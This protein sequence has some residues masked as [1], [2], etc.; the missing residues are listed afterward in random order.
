MENNTRRNFLQKTMMASASIPILNLAFMESLKAGIAEHKDKSA[1]EIAADETFWYQIQKAYTVSPHFTNL[2]NGYFSLA[3][4]EVLEAQ[5]KNIRMINEQPSWYMRKRQWE[6]RAAIKERLAN[7]AGVSPEEIALLR[8][9]TEALNIVIQGID[10]QAGDEAIVSDQDYGSMLEAFDMR[11]KRFGIVVKKVNIPLHPKSD[12]EIV[13]LF[14]SAITPKTKVIHVTHLINL[15]GQILPVKKIADMAHSKGIEVISDSA[16]A[17]GQLNFKIPELDCDYMGTSLHK[18]LGCPLG[19][20]MLYVKKE[21]IKGL[22][23]LMGDVNM[24]DDDIRKLEHIGTHPCSADL[25]IANA[26]KFHEMIGADRKAAR[27]FYLKNYWTEKAADIPNVIINTPKEKSRSCAIA[28]VGIEGISPA[29][30]AEILYKRY[31]IFTV[32]IDHTAIKGVRVTP[33][34]YTTTSELDN[35]VKALEEISES[36]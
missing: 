21:K 32:A 31:K 17:F 28:N 14:E 36:M 30:L 35:F 20:G 22:W 24:P 8:N 16:H 3:A 34:L 11:S 5:L 27:L 25:A 29:E 1:K 26:I 2:E 13:A 12:E 6:D 33:H 7:L 18:W 9:T 4:D 19:L 10:M 23:P 15:S